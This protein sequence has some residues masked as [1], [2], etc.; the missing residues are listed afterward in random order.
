MTF[1]DEN[2]ISNAY[3]PS[4][5]KWDAYDTYGAYLYAQTRGREDSSI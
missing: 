3:I 1:R 2:K 4:T 5:K